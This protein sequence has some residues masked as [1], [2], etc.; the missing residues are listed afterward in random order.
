MT[1]HTREAALKVETPSS[2]GFIEGEAPLVSQ[3]F[4]PHP[5]LMGRRKQNGLHRGSYDVYVSFVDMSHRLV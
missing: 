3:I 5:R 2:L 1:V 4:V